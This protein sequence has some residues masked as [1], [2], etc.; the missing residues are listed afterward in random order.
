M[1]RCGRGGAGKPDDPRSY[2]RGSVLPR[3]ALHLLG[4][5]LVLEVARLDHRRQAGRLPGPVVGALRLLHHHGLGAD[6]RLVVVAGVR[7]R[8]EP[9][10]DGIAPD[11]EVLPDEE[12]RV[13][14]DLLHGRDGRRLDDGVGEGVGRGEALVGFSEE[15]SGDG[16]REARRHRPVDLPHVGDVAHDDAIQRLEVRFA[17][18]KAVCGEHLP[19]HDPRR[20]DVGAPVDEAALD[21]LGRHVRKLPLHLTGAGG[22]EPAG[23]AGDPEIDDPRHAVDPDEDVLRRH[24][25]VHDVERAVEVVTQLVRGVEAHEGIDRDAGQHGRSEVVAPVG[26]VA[27]EASQALP[28]DVFEHQVVTRFALPYVEDGHDVGV[29]NARRE[30][31]LVQKHRDEFLLLREVRVEPLDGDETAEPP[32]PRDAREVHRPHATSGD[33]RDQLVAVEALGP[34][35]AVEELERG[36]L[37]P[38]PGTP[39]GAGGTANVACSPDALRR[40]TS[41]PTHDLDHPSAPR[42]GPAP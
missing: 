12:F 1:R 27:A 38:G 37:H 17:A 7:V 18:E 34:S 5:R 8:L 35:A 28:F 41:R 21:L 11:P 4:E 16:L 42:S 31:R 23:G 40:S 22:G 2:R 25:A 14:R 19:E 6:L 15:G 29:M 32:R 24:V 30:A 39:E 20:E 10:P 9:L 26:R 36:L 33:L 13:G 3:A